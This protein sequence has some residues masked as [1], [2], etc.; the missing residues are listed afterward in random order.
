MPFDGTQVETPALRRAMLIEA[1]RAEMP[2]NFKWN[3]RVVRESYDCGSRGCA[4]GLASILWPSAAG[5]LL[6][7]T[8]I[9]DDLKASFFGI[10]IESVED[11]FFFGGEHDHYYLGSTD[12]TPQ[13]V[14][15]ALEAIA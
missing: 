11:I 15:A 13:M 9:H 3:F 5:F 2:I 8:E 14:A 6:D 10:P 1:L 7:D 4:L 12:V